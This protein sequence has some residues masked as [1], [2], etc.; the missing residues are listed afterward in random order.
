[1]CELFAISSC[2]PATVTITLKEFQ[3][4]GGS[5]HHNS[6]GWG[7][8]IY[9]DG[10]ARVL[11]DTSAARDSSYFDFIR[12]H[13]YPTHCI[14]TH[15]RQATVGGVSLRNTQPFSRELWGQLHC[16]AHNGDLEFKAPL[17]GPMEFQPIGDTDSELAFCSLLSRLKTAASQQGV[18]LTLEQ[19]TSLIRDFANEFRELGT[20][21]F[22]YSDG[23]YLFVHSHRRTQADG[24]MRSPGLHFL[25]REDHHHDHEHQQ[26]DG[27]KIHTEEIIPDMAL[28]ASVPLTDEGWQ[29]MEAGTVAVLRDGALLGMHY[30]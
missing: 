1:M 13:N 21:N 26:V 14:I 7:I 10:D 25:Q 22:F 4:H 2:Q 19:R 16:F 9:E 17:E 23:E 20:F 18:A 30:S 27:L 8:A 15:I 11:R 29:P 24:I 3:Q 12:S 28:V 6:D 5:H